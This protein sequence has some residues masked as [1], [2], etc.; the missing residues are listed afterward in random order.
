MRV[1]GAK[2]YIFHRTFTHQI[3]FGDVEL[4]CDMNRKEAEAGIPGLV[5]DTHVPPFK[6]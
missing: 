3:E 2:F 1:S 4:Q 6:V 5:E